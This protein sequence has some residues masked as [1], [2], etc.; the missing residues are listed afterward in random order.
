MNT[1]DFEYVIF[2]F[3]LVSQIIFF[4]K[5]RI[6]IKQ[7]NE[8]IIDAK[9]IQLTD[10]EL[11][12]NE[13]EGFIADP[14]TLSNFNV[15]NGFDSEV[16]YIEAEDIDDENSAAPALQSNIN[17]KVTKIKL[18]TTTNNTSLIFSEIIVSINKYLVRNR[19][20]IADFNLIKDIVERNTDTI[21]EEVNLTLS[22]PL[23]LGLM[24]TMLG[25][26][27]GIFSMSQ[28]FHENIKDADLSN[29]IGILLGS[30][31]IAMVG[32]FFGLALTIYNSA[33]IF[34]GSKFKLEAK[35]NQF[36]TFIQVELLPILNQGIG[37][38]FESLQR[39]LSSFNE[40]FDYNLDRLSTVFDKNY[41]SILLY[42]ELLKD[43]D[44]SKV[45]EI[46][47]YNL[48]VLKELN[49][50]V[51][52]FERFNSL[53]E[54]VNKY[55]NGTYLLTDKTNELLA[56]TGNF[57]KIANTIEGNIYQSNQLLGFLSGHFQDLEGYRNTVNESA[58]NVSF[59]IKDTFDELKLSLSNSGQNLS[60]E[61]AL[62]S[63]E[64]EKLFNAFTNELQQVFSN[65]T[66]AIRVALEEKKSSLEYL[67]FLEPLLNEVKSYKK[68]TNNNVSDNLN[69]QISELANIMST[70]NR[71]LR[72]I[73][74]NLKLPFYKKIFSKNRN[75]E[76]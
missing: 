20:S 58:A 36:Y 65:Q 50:S 13:I 26:V 2:A 28:L 39:N 15:N 1:E 5:T 45:A 54:N 55:L 59:G 19:H 31:K 3:I 8:S 48:Q 23:Y 11:T 18:I 7:F 68:E 21:E 41:D 42:K 52:H 61:A 51:I 16:E 12:E 74:E 44:Q 57:E 27:I 38:T 34:K 67:R 9:L 62:R 71:I 69:T 6:K 76:T 49:I 25:I 72:R 75:E 29:G 17:E 56:R 66:E 30:V 32:S 63:I 22:T 73:D 10:F 14:S 60:N 46:T 35:K 40:K 64:N 47:K 43:L 70:S 53:F 24:G 4:I 37:A 33:I